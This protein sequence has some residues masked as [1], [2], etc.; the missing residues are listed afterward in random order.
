[1]YR[2]VS[3]LADVLR[4]S[5]DFRTLLQLS[6]WLRPMPDDDKYVRLRRLS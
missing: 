3:L 2:S 4:A 1:M 5:D 6:D